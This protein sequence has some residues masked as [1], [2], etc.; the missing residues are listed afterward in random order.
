MFGMKFYIGY[1]LS[2]RQLRYDNKL[3]FTTGFLFRQ[4]QKEPTWNLPRSA[5]KNPKIYSEIASFTP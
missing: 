2:Q 4:K 3:V 1:L 5:H